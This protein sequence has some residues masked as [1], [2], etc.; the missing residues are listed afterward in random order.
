MINPLSTQMTLATYDIKS[1]SAT[2]SKLSAQ[3]LKGSVVM[4][5]QKLCGNKD[6]IQ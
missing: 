3:E 5:S 6:P 1:V 4:L 2:N